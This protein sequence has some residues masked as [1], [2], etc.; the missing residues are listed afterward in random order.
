M[1]IYPLSYRLSK[2][3]TLLLLTC[4]LVFLYT[5]DKSNQL[6]IVIVVL[7]LLDWLQV[8]YELFAALFG[9]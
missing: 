6:V 9:W 8:M 3:L 1:M 7:L 2:M 4:F 5:T